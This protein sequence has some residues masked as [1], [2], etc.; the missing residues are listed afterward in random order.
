MFNRANTQIIK[1]INWGKT[2]WSTRRITYADP[3]RAGR[4]PFQVYMLILSIAAGLPTALGVTSPTSIS[5]VLPIWLQ[6]MWGWCLV[7]GSA[8]GL[9][10]SY[11]RGSIVNA[12][13][14]ERVGL[15]LVGTAA[16]IFG[17][18]IVVWFRWTGVASGLIIIGYGLSCVRRARD[19][20]LVIRTALFNVQAGR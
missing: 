18:V 4:H 19:I 12:L 5:S 7:L 11:W 16:L 8:T 13:T 14:I 10:G 9:V 17:F 20:G 3:L 1:I 2:L 6:L 15:A